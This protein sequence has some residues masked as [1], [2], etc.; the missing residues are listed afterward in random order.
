MR[1]GAIL[2][3]SDGIMVARGDLGVELP[4]QQVTNAQK[5]MVAACKSV[6]KPVIVATQMLE[7]MAKNP[8]P[9]RAEVADVTNAIYDG[10][11]CVML[12]GETAKGKYPV[13]SVKIMNDI[14]LSAER[15][16][17]EGGVGGASVRRFEAPDASFMGA[18]AKAAVTAADTQQATA[19]LV[20][21]LK[22][23]T[24][25][26]LV[27]AYRPQVPI[28]CFCDN[29]K[30]GRQLMIYRGIHPIVGTGSLE[31]AVEDAKKLGFVKVG[32]SV[33]YVDV[34]TQHDTAT[35]KLVHVE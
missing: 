3:A 35:M 26:A 34:D 31:E 1:I 9:T 12:S 2:E 10:A 11:D 30:L 5:E 18:I 19:I 16:A 28:L 6:G 7:S 24:L 21:T 33:V 22:D 29:A 8:R 27:S 15:Y 20:S 17:S 32:D 25:P 14:I 4:L 13:E 23:G